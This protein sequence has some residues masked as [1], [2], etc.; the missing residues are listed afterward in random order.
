[1]SQRNPRDV[2]VYLDEGLKGWIMATAW[3][4]HWR[5][6]AWY[7]LGDLVQE[8]YL[9]YLK[10]RNRYALRKPDPGHPT[11]N[12]RKPTEIQRRHFM[13]LVQRTFYNRIMTLASRYTAGREE[14]IV[15][16]AEEDENTAL[17]RLLPA[18]SEVASVAVALAKAP[19]EIQQALQKVIADFRV[20]NE[21]AEYRRS[22]LYWQGD[23]LRRGRRKLRETN[24]EFWQ[25]VAGDGELPE[26]LE[27]YLVGSDRTDELLERFAH[28][29][30]QDWGRD[31]VNLN[32]I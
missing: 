25:R 22:R 19:L 10:C 14:P 28:W 13:S 9:C 12:T 31:A 5:V 16:R 32:T 26:K 20:G 3:K 2:D 30:Q 1:M 24:E 27:T 17:E 21:G 29:L 23:R 7:E 4:E 18:Q 8:G 15:G 11:L 6:A